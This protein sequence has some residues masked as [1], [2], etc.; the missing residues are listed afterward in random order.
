MEKKVIIITLGSILLIIGAIFL[1]NIRSS[2]EKQNLVS[3]VAKPESFSLEKMPS[4][5]L[6]EYSDSSGF[7]FSFPEDVKIQR[8][9]DESLYSNLTLT[10]DGLDGN[11]AF[12]LS[13]TSYS[14]LEDW[15]KEN[16]AVLSGLLIKESNLGNISGISFNNKDKITFIAIDQGVEFKI[17]VDY[18]SQKKYWENVYS[19]ILNSF[20]FVSSS[21]ETK[22]TESSQVSS[23]DD[24]VF[25]GEEVVE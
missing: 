1:L 19:N 23:E 12:T 8:I 3:G 21:T 25:E 4:T 11:I 6:K 13:D 22:S 2:K 10:A 7:T 16:N 5:I 17:I 9:D 15:K 20:S 18:K 24:V 14:S